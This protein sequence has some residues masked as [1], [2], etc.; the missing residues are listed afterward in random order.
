MVIVT[1]EWMDSL[2]GLLCDVQCIPN[3]LDETLGDDHR[4]D[5]EKWLLALASAAGTLLT[6]NNSPFGSGDTLN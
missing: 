2:I 4:K 1:D 3:E 5:T 6:A